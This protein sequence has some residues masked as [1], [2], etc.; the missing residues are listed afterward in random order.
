MPGRAGRPELRVLVAALPPLPIVGRPCW[1]SPA[2]VTGEGRAQA[3]TVTAF[4]CRGAGSTP[5]PP[6]LAPRA[7]LESPSPCQ[8]HLR[9][10]SEP[11]RLQQRP[12]PALSGAHRCR[13]AEPLWGGAGCQ[14]SDE[15]RF[16]L[17]SPSASRDHAPEPMKAPRDAPLGRAEERGHPEPRQK[18]RPSVILVGCRRCHR[19]LAALSTRRSGAPAAPKNP[20]HKSCLPTGSGSRR[21]AEGTGGGSA[22]TK[23]GCAAQGAASAPRPRPGHNGTAWEAARLPWER[24]GPRDNAGRHR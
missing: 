2:A 11:A 4:C 3:R 23:P 9:A 19:A 16:S 15:I 18:K 24:R 21:A 17:I 7:S 8:Q 12:G 20:S 22:G 1:A 10:S 6:I 5:R 14:E 13:A